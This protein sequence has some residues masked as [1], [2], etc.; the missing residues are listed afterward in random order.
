LEEIVPIVLAAGASRRMG[1]PK[2]AL[3]LGG[4]TALR[5]VLDACRAAGLGR[6]IVVAGAHPEETR[7]AARGAA[8]DPLVVVNASWERGRTTSIR[9]GLAALGAEARAFLLWPVDTPL[10][11]EGGTLELLLSARARRPSARGWVPSHEG[12]RGHPILLDRSVAAELEALADDASARDVVRGLARR[13]ELEH[14]LVP[15]P[16]VL[17][18]MDTPDDHARIV[19]ELER[20]GPRRPS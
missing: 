8:R 13:G 11:G 20:R 19:R 18:D 5:W 4:R 10:A 15:E 6:A 2:A 3:E 17:W 7:A 16:A 9:A 12:R 14:V 1:S